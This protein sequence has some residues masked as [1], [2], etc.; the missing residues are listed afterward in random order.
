MQ[1]RWLG[2][3]IFLF[4]GMLLCPAI[5]ADTPLY[6]TKLMLEGKH[7]VRGGVSYLDAVTVA[8]KFGEEDPRLHLSLHAAAVDCVSPLHDYKKAESFFKRDIALLEK[9]DVDFPDL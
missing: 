4:A 6:W 5:A 3:S 2:L 8:E 7:L 1:V 9:I